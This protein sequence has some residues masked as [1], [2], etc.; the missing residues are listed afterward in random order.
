MSFKLT[1]EDE[2]KEMVIS[3]YGL[4]YWYY[5]DGCASDASEGYEE[6]A[7]SDYDPTL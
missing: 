7:V 5:L 3:K 4:K 1:P 2:F 6:D